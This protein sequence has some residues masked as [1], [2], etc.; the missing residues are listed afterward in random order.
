MAN[1][2]IRDVSDEVVNQFKSIAK[3]H[4]RSLQQELKAVLE[5]TVSR[6]S[7]DIFRKAA[8]IRKRL[9]KKNIFFSDSVQL[10]RKDRAR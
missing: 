5:N 3:K 7:S 10:L 2:L 1:V 4:N 9:R 8:E 6:S